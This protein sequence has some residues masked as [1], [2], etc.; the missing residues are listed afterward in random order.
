MK[1]KFKTRG[2]ENPLP[3]KCEVG[4]SVIWTS[5]EESKYPTIQK[6]SNRQNGS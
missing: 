4:N 2:K 5:I 6:N 3:G 1:R